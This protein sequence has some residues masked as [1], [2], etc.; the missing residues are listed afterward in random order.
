MAHKISALGGLSEIA[1]LCC[2]PWHAALQPL[3]RREGWRYFA[4]DLLWIGSC[5]LIYF[6]GFLA[7]AHPRCHTGPWNWGENNS[8]SYP[9]GVLPFD[10]SSLHVCYDTLP[11]R[12]AKET[13][14]VSDSGSALMNC[15]IY[16]M[17]ER[18]N[19]RSS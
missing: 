19:K 3:D 5:F 15:F 11:K 17:Q 7:P 18:R 12:V 8:H 9:F 14:A 2:F 6:R 1:L 16:E 4:S 10:F 13:I